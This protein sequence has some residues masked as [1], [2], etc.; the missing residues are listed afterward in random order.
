MKT[1]RPSVAQTASTQ[2]LQKSPQHGR[3]AHGV[4]A[5]ALSGAT[6]SVQNNQAVY[7]QVHSSS[8]SDNCAFLITNTLANGF[9]V[10]AVSTLPLVGQK[11]WAYLPGTPVHLE[12]SIT[13][14]SGVVTFWKD[15]SPVCATS[16]NG[17]FAGGAA[18]ARFGSRAASGDRL[19]RTT[20]SG[21]QVAQAT[22]KNN[23][24][25]IKHRAPRFASNAQSLFKTN[26]T[27]QVKTTSKKSF[28]FH[29]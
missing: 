10:E 1:R 27:Y 14:G 26:G 22:L 8:G 2:R 17:S 7:L 20:F 15:G 3:D 5:M 18:S 19:L 28:S 12:M 23:T 6:P 9:Q 21:V 25:A 11:A 4:S 29:Q 24:F 16:S 13:P